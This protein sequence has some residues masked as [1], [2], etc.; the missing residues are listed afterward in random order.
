MHDGDEEPETVSSE[1]SVFGTMGRKIGRIA[2]PAGT[3]VGR[4]NKRSERSCA[5]LSDLV[6]LGGLE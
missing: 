4:Q 5:W 1:K 2:P 3:Q 6:V